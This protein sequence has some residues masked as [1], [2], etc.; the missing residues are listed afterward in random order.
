MRKLL[1]WVV[2][3][4]AV[5]LFLIGCMV[6]EVSTN[7]SDEAEQYF[8][9]AAFNTECS[10]PNESAGCAELYAD[11]PR[12]PYGVEIDDNEVLLAYGSYLLDVRSH[13]LSIASLLIGTSGVLLAAS[14]IVHGQT[15][16]RQEAKEAWILHS[17]PQGQEEKVLPAPPGK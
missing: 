10:S 11:E 13:I 5:F 8:D 17:E 12:W 7:I 16:A 6:V 4:A 1:S 9:R 2:N 15:K 14:V 3:L